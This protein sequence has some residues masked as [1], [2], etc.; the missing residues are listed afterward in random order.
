MRDDEDGTDGELQR[1]CRSC[2]HPVS[3]P[4]GS[5]ASS[6]TTAQRWL[7]RVALAAAVAAAAVLVGFARIASVLLV[8]V[9]LVALAVTA[10]GIWW[11]LTTRG[12]RRLLSLLLVVAV[13]VAVMVLYAW[14]GLIWVVLVSSALWALA[15][16]TGRAALTRDRRRA[17]TPRSATAEHE[18][19]APEHPVIIM[20]PHS[21]GGKVVKYNLAERAEELG[22]DVVMMDVSGK[23]D[24][25][26]LARAAVSRGADLLGVAGGDGTQAL[27]AGVAAE[28]GLPFMVITA[29]TRNHFALDLGLDRDDPSTCLNALTDG[30]ELRVDLGFV[31]SRPFVNNVSFGA[32]GA[33]VHSPAYRGDKVQTLLDMLPDLL[34]G[35]AGPYLAVRAEGLTLDGARA[36][37]VSNNP[38]GTGDIAGLGRRVRLDSGVLGILGVTVENAAQAA[39]LLRGR[40]GD[41]LEVRTAAEVV[42]DAAEPRIQIAVDGEAL[43]LSTPVRC[44][45]RPGVLRVRVPRAR[46]GVPVAKPPM[47]WRRLREMAL[48]MAR[49]AGTG[50]SSG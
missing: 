1:S 32:Y 15:V 17:R 25:V 18:A 14:V 9:A 22:A 21:G 16:S 7:A 49:T 11:L 38:Y 44:V 46:P 39:G 34:A 40:H 8:G 41:G 2:A 3:A 50:R 10:A 45:V 24:V 31:G 47:D 19:P 23:A 30:V 43:S 29:G 12:V 6:V 5:S 37:L 35:H 28:Y 4:P 27:V 36:V 13:P 48:T 26:G 42:V 33:V 20:N